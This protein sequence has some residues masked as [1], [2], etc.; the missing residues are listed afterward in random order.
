[1]SWLP[2]ELPPNVR[3]ILSMINDTT[4]HNELM[5]RDVKPQELHMT[6]LDFDSRKV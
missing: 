2:K 3:C 5:S 6:P 4:Q 1:M